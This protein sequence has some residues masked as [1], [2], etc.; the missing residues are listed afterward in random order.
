MMRERERDR[1]FFSCS[2]QVTTP[3]RARSVSLREDF[4]RDKR[5]MFG[6][7]GILIERRWC[8]RNNIYP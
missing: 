3:S 7:L 8:L 6:N 2:R 5:L 4:E 1:D